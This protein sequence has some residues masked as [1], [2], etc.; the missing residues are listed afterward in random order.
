MNA[1]ND[2]NSFAGIDWFTFQATNA[3]IVMSTQIAT[4]AAADAGVATK[5]VD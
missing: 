1:L 5:E 2:H 4:M 3:W